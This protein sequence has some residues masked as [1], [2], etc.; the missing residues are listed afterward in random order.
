MPARGG[1][2]RRVVGAVA[3]TMAALLPAGNSEAA[4]SN[5]RAERERVRAE[6]AELAGDLDAL[7]AT[8]AEV[9]AALDDLNA[10]VSD[11]RALLE[12]AQSAAEQA[13]AGAEL[14][15]KEEDRSAAEVAALEE[16][17]RE[18]AVQTFMRP[19]GADPGVVL[20]ASS[21]S[22]AARRQALMSFS[23]SNEAELLDA[24]R[25]S[26]ADL[27]DAR[28]E[29]EQAAARAEE[30]RAE[31][32]GRVQQ[33]DQAQAQQQEF[34]N[35]VEQRLDAT[36]AE[37]ASLAS[38]DAQLADQIRADEARIA[39]QLRASRPPPSAS[40]PSAPS[41]P[42]SSSGGASRSVGAAP[43]S[44][45]SVRGIQVASSIADQLAALLD[46]ADADGVNLGGGGYRDPSAQVALRR[47]NC[48]TSDYAVYDMS[49]S[50]CSPPT[51]R[52][53]S[54]MHER[55]L[56]IDFTYNGSL[57][58]SRSN[59]G[60]AWLSAN[61]AGFGFYNLPSEPWHWST[62]GN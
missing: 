24:L 9:T 47:S 4:E 49:P 30:E 22:E 51:A 50:E 36:L 5:P 57:I 35:S 44:I 46:A 12:D 37:A 2:L 33:L 21:V 26:R 19:T 56:A 43:G 54:S 45:V 8:D 17:A 58:S 59:A 48:G 15:R 11:Q 32:A 28:Q 55:G 10:N 20:R 39:A 6:Q 18:M 42:R 60:F 31:V 52:P 25:A 1:A 38:L 27:E 3:V 16:Q 23:A 62:N 40:S 29:A 61:A 34:A 53:G 14:A 7:R 41:A 13:S